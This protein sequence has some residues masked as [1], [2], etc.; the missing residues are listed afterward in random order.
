MYVVSPTTLDSD[1]SL[2][3]KAPVAIHARQPH[4]SL[5]SLVGS[6]L[7]LIPTTPPAVK[8]GAEFL[9]VDDNPVNLRILCAFMKKLGREYGTAT[10]GEDAVANFKAN[11]S[12]YKCVF[13]DI[14]MP[15]LDGMAA[16]RLIRQH[17]RES[18]LESAT[19]IALTGLASAAIQREAYESGM[20]LFLTKPVTL[21][22]LKHILS[23]EKY[24]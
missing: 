1:P 22:E 7:P 15:R 17:E 12:H 3:M 13:M 8:T 21:K 9:L 19:I 23:T 5:D 24:I 20:N 2:I 16:T 10:N 4:Q 11:P 14:S 18:G 6:P